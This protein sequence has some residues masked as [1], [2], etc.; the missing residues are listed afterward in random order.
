MRTIH[1]NRRRGELARHDWLLRRHLRHRYQLDS[2]P[3]L[4]T[5]VKLALKASFTFK[6]GVRNAQ[7]VQLVQHDVML[8]SL[9]VAFDGLRF[10]F[11]SDLHIEGVPDLVPRLIALIE[12]LEYDFC[13]MGGDYRF[14]ISGNETYPNSLLAK[15]MP[16]LL[17]KTPVHGI[18]GNH[19]TWE[20]GQFLAQLGVNILT[21][22]HLYLH[23]DEASLAFVMLEDAHYF[24]AADFDLAEL[25]LDKGVCR[26]LLSH[27]PELYKEAAS[28]GY[29]LYLAGHTHGGQICLPGEFPLLANANIPR[30]MVAGAWRFGDLQGYTSRGAGSGIVPVRFFSKPEVVLVQLRSGE[31][32]T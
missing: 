8:P 5:G 24:D 14:R 4:K 15:L 21:N 6:R 30:N 19:D 12:P 28:R 29:E 13:I 18:L 2:I 26:I 23:R 1:P 16:V 31:K 27:S 3:W 11:F 17:Q 20:T 25:G 10:L 22:E 9:P 32:A 7:R